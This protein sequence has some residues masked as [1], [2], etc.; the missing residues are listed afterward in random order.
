MTALPG[1]D[2]RAGADRAD[3][4]ENCLARP[5]SGVFVLD[6]HRVRRVRQDA[7]DAVGRHGGEVVLLVTIYLAHAANDLWQHRTQF[8]SG[9]RWWP[10]FC[11]AALAR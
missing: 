1:V 2:R 11:F 3:D 9:T 8:V 5:A 4:V 10:P 6:D 7:V